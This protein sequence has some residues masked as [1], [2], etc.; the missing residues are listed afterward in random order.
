MHI[1]AE[2]M[3]FLS[4]PRSGVGMQMPALLR[5][6]SAQRTGPGSHAGASKPLT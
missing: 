1:E 4:F 3:D 5:H 6:L 2:K